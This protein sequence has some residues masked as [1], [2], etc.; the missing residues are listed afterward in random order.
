[1]L[2]YE[3]AWES[4]TPILEETQELILLGDIWELA[5]QKLETAVEASRPFFSWLNHRFPDLKIVMIPGN[6]DHHLVLRAS[7]ERVEASI[8]GGE[9]PPL[10]RVP[11][12][13]KIIQSCAPDLKV[14]SAYPVW[15][16]D[17]VWYHHGHYLSTHLQVFSW[18]AFDRLQ[19]K[20]WGQ[21]R[22][23][24]NLSV[25][26]YEALIGPLHELWHQIAQLPN[27]IARQAA[28]QAQLAR[29]GHLLNL[30][31]DLRESVA[32]W[33]LKGPRPFFKGSATILDEA[34]VMEDP[35][36]QSLSEISPALE[37]VLN[38]LE[39]TQSKVIY[40]HTHY[41][42]ANQKIAAWSTYNCGS[43]FNDARAHQKD[44][45]H[46]PMPGSVCTVTNDTIDLHQLLSKDDL[47]VP[48]GP[49]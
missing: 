6:H 38:N 2:R 46:V 12:A 43:W 47:P 32:R 26:D 9:P 30:P 37:Q 15:I 16:S 11:L 45:P 14:C 33:V 4:L 48:S 39:V 28:I 41:P 29:L 21:T 44:G 34:L 31:V 24:Q 18:Q 1:M 19:W 25:I 7:Q 35:K 23:Y 27:G 40:A 49:P 3:W 10:F 17:D 8:L 36:D 5:F 20:L 22:R 42:V 13:E